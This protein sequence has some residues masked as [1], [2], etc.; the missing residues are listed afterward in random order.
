[1]ALKYHLVS[2]KDLRKGAPEDA[3]L[4]YARVRASGRVTF[5]E[6]CKSVTRMSSGSPGDTAGV[7]DALLYVMEENLSKGNIVE[8][9]NLGY[10][11]MIA[12]SPGVET[13]KDFHPRLFKKPRI[14]FTPG[15]LLKAITTQLE[16]NLLPVKTIQG[17]PAPEDPDDD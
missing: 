10:F 14:L 3:T 1:M 16:Y 5:Q 2:G 12:G 4:L 8:L 17:Q 6:L 9:S 15:T 11:R 7:L 13:E